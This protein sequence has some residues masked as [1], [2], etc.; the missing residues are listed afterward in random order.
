MLSLGIERM[1][2]M[3]GS[4]CELELS[5]VGDSFCLSFRLLVFLDLTLVCGG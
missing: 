3:I 1:M 2:G 5:D 4:G